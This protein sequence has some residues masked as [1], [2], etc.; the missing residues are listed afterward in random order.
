MT[1]H[2]PYGKFRAGRGSRG[3]SPEARQGRVTERVPDRGDDLTLHHCVVTPEEEARREHPRHR[4]QHQSA[5]TRPPLAD[6]TQPPQPSPAAQRPSATA[7]PR[8]TDQMING[9]SPG[10][11]PTT[12]TNALGHCQPEMDTWSA[13]SHASD[14]AGHLGLALQ[15]GGHSCRARRNWRPV[16][17][18]RK[19]CT[20]ALDRYGL[21][22]RR[23]RE[24][25]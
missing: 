21:A 24:P 10:M 23:I 4:T 11:T 19:I 9:V 17:P 3:R 13:S 6:R 2:T 7:L 14:S 15:A 5:A 1:A 16:E 20:A 18:S 25:V 8:A 12:D 22:T